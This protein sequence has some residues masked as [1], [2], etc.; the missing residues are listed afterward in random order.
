[1]TT[2][3]GKCATEICSDLVLKEMETI[4][5][6]EGFKEKSKRRKVKQKQRNKDVVYYLSDLLCTL[7]VVGLIYNL[8]FSGE[9]F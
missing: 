3:E 5:K 8:E 7:F 2:S 1:L 9:E 4:G 6:E